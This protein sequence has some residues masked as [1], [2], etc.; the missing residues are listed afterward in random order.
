MH[1]TEQVTGITAKATKNMFDHTKV[2]FKFNR[3]YIK[4]I[5]ITKSKY[6]IDQTHKYYNKHYIKH[7]NITKSK[8]IIDQIG[9]INSISDIFINYHRHYELCLSTFK[10]SGFFLKSM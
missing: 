8:Y 5:N 4:H 1:F 3:H 2:A 10:V 7:I 6:I 9:I